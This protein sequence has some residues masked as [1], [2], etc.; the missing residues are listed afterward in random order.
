MDLKLSRIFVCGGIEQLWES[1]SVVADGKALISQSPCFEYRGESSYLIR[2]SSMNNQRQY[3]AA[4][5]LQP[6]PSNRPRES[7]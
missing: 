6:D 7:A 3:M 2:R 5:A 1:D 4:I